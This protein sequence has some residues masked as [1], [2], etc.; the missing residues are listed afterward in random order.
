MTRSVVFILGLAVLAVGCGAAS[1]TEPSAGT[2]TTSTFT[3]PL[4][5]TNE[6]PA[7]TNADQ[8]ASGTATI[9]LTVTR[10]DSGEI[11]SASADIQIAVT[12]FPPGTVITDAHIHNASAGA[13]GAVVVNAGLGSGELVLVN[14]TGSVTKNGIIVSS[15][16]AGAILNNPTGHY[17]NVHTALN[18]DGAIRGQ[19]A[20][21]GTT[22]DP[23][24]PT[25]Y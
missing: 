15:A 1:P 12:D 22:F 5:T 20:G 4:S 24:I 25:P 2:R 9:A 17:F 6:V 10:D 19:L 13:N 11:T 14:G 23:G 3:V 16:R 21:G 8:G 7:I 18:P